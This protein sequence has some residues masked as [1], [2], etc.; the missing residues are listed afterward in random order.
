MIKIAGLTTRIF[1]MALLL[2][3]LVMP[4][5]VFATGLVL[6]A[7]S[8]FGNVDDI[9]LPPAI[10]PSTANNI[11]TTSATI[12]CSVISLN[13]ATTVDVFFEWGAKSSYGNTTPVEKLTK[14]GTFSANLENL[15]PNTTY[16]FRGKADGGTPGMA[17]GSDVT[18]TT[19]KGPAGFPV[20]PVAS[21][22]AAI[23]I[24]AF[25]VFFVIRFKKIK[26]KSVA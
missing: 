5:P 1:S 17:F 12:T 10:G 25:A 15:T 20:W 11:T 6:P 18:F 14:P 8:G 19:L 22:A 21:I 9:I 7:A 26:S 3:A 23:L 24:V 13:S 4:S 16:H 2:C